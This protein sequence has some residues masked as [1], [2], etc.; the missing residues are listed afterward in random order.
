MWELLVVL[1]LMGVLLSSVTPHFSTA[2]NQVRVRINSANVQ[3]I[4][5]A[6]QIYR[7]DVGTYPVSVLDLVHAPKGV[8]GWHG[9]YLNDIPINPFDSDQV[10][11]IDT[12][13]QVN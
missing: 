1:F 5:G 6:A 12:L 11:R 13:G 8:S 10:Y 9:P 4:E 7:I 3:K 2:E